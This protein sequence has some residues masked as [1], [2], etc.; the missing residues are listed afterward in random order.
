MCKWT[1]ASIDARMLQQKC[2]AKLGSG[3][4]YCSYFCSKS[5]THIFTVILTILLAWSYIETASHEDF[6]VMLF[7]LSTICGCL[8]SQY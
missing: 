8:L 5:F 2:G 6:G 3:Q 7:M 4:Y 1:V